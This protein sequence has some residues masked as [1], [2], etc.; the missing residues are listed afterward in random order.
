MGKIAEMARRVKARMSW[1]EYRA[2]DKNVRIMPENGEVVPAHDVDGREIPDPVPIAPP[3]GWFKQPSMFD[4]V[5]AMVRSEQMRMY[6][7]TQGAETFDDASDFDVPD[8]MFPASQFEAEDDFEPPVDFEARRQAMYRERFWA[9]NDMAGYEEWVAE[10]QK[11]GKLPASRKSASA[12]AEPARPASKPPEPG[13]GSSDKG[14]VHF[15]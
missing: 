1:D 7:E 4:H 12:P 13:S 10:A 15:T 9:E 3:I 2:L 6:A 14:P 11:A 8:D 5:R